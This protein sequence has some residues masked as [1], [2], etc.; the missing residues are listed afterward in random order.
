MWRVIAVM[1]YGRI[2]GETVLH[3]VVMSDR[4]HDVG[5]I[6]V[7]GLHHVVSDRCH[8]AQYSRITSCGE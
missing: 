6:G 2:R 1:M 7:L 3:H 8:D 4:C 5:G